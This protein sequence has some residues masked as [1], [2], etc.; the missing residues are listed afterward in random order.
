MLDLAR[1]DPE[2]QRA[3][4]PMGGRV[5]VAANDRH[6]RLG[7]PQL[8]ADHVHDPLLRRVQPE[9]LDR[10]LPG[11]RLQHAHLFGGD[12][13]GDRQAAIAGG[14]VVV[15]RGQRAFRTAH[16]PSGQ[17]EPVEGLG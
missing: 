16:L 10:E 7:G 12:G 2:G 11:V 4:R 14:H 9:Q 8:R 15:H 1:A 17:T 3:E 5:R 13:I 6:A